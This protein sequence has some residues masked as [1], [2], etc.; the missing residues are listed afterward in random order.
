MSGRVSRAL[1]G[2]ALAV[3]W[4]ASAHASFISLTPT[5]SS[6]CTGKKLEVKILAVNKGD[7]SAFNVQAVVRAGGRVLTAE[8]MSELPVSGVYRAELSFPLP[9]GLPGSYPLVLTMHYTDANQYQFSALTAQTFVRQKEL[10]SPL[11]GQAKPVTFWQEGELSFTVKNT[12]DR[13]LKIRTSLV[14]PR[15]LSV[16]VADRE[17]FIDPQSQQSTLFKVSNFSALSGSTYQLFLV[18]EVKDGGQYYTSIVP[19]TVRIVERKT[20]F[21]LS[22]ITIAVLLAGLIVIFLGAQLIKR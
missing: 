20:I 16:A 22:Y 10:F 18:C 1:L 7:E 12:S 17:L 15:E 4:A 21:G 13:P 3:F 6:S 8:K 14:T 9:A 5:L 2:C 19:G 11:C